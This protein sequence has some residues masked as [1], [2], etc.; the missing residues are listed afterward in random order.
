MEGTFLVIGAAGGIGQQVVETALSQGWRVIA[1]LR[2]PAKLSLTHPLLTVVKGDVLQPATY[3]TY[4]TEST[5]VLSAIGITRGVFR[6][7][8]TTLYSEGAR[9]ILGAMQRR[10]ARRAYF[11]SASA[12][13]ISPVLPAFVRWV[14]KHI[15]QK[16]LRQMYADLRIMEGLVKES[17]LDWTIVRP[18]RLTDKKLTG[19][20]RYAVNSFLRN[21]LSISRADVAHFMVHHASDRGTYQGVV[22][23]GY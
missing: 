20:Y 19:K 15:V 1:V 2:T 7:E 18:P 22:E 6:D 11:I 16:L 14:A 9:Q 21:A 13:E 5:V 10:G 23:L 4:L 12:V 3:E 17:G 8:A